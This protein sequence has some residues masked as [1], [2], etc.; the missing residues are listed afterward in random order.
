[1]LYH[2]KSIYL[3]GICLFP[4]RT[5]FTGLEHVRLS[6]I[7]TEGHYKYQPY[8]SYYCIC[9]FFFFQYSSCKALSETFFL[10]FMPTEIW[11]PKN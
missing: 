7:L 1:M 6:L 11:S 9:P 4:C 8:E 10:Y 3:D 5:I 2:E